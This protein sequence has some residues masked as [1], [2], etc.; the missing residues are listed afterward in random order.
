MSAEFCR[1]TSVLSN[2]D[3]GADYRL[4][5]LRSPRIAATAVPGQFVHVRVPALDPSALRRPISVCDADPDTGVLTLLFRMVGRG[6]IALATVREGDEVD[7]M[8]PLGNGFPLPPDGSSVLLVGGG[9]GVAPLHFLARSIL[10]ARTATGS[11]SSSFE[12]SNLRT[13]EPSNRDTP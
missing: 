4:L 5:R 13:F 6:T 11:S 7:L 8:G 10:R 2:Q 9:Y 1:P 12:R 3:L